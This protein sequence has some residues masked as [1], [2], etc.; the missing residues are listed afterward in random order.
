ML[1][2]RLFVGFHLGAIVWL[3]PAVSNHFFLVFYALLLLSIVDL[4]RPREALLGLQ[5]CRFLVVIVLFYSG[6]QK[7]LYG[8]YFH[9]QLLT[10]IQVSSWA[11]K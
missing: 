8:T 10:W 7:V 5:A 4:D 11:W 2:V 6:L 1:A 3:F 9:A